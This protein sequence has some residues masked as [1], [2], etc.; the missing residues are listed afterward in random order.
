MKA[1]LQFYDDDGYALFQPMP[2]CDDGTVPFADEGVLNRG[3]LAVKPCYLPIA[4]VK[5]LLHYEMERF[6][7]R[8]CD[9]C[10]A[11]KHNRCMDWPKCQQ[12]EEEE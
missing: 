2:I 3:F 4:S 12:E 10:D 7:N 8:I 1:A 5:V 11:T 6:R 9:E